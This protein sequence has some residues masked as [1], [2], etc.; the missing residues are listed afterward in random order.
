MPK[1]G[2]FGADFHLGAMQYGDER[3]EADYRR[4]M[5]AFFDAG[6]ANPNVAFLQL[7][8]DTSDNPNE[9]K[10]V[11]QFVR[12]QIK[13]AAQSGKIVYGITGNHDIG[14]PSLAAALDVDGFVDAEKAFL[15]ALARGEAFRPYGE[16]G[17]AV[18]ALHYTTPKKLWE[19]LQDIRNREKPENM[20]TELWLHQ[21]IA[22]GAQTGF[23][24]F[25][26][27]DFVN[28]GW[29]TVI[30]GDI[31]NGGIYPVPARDT[32]GVLVYPGSPEMTDINEY[33]H[34]TRGFVLHSPTDAETTPNIDTFAKIPYANR[35]YRTFRFGT[36]RSPEHLQLILD[37]VQSVTQEREQPIVRIVTTDLSW[38]QSPELLPVVL[39]LMV[40]QPKREPTQMVPTGPALASVEG[41]LFGGNAARY[42][43]VFT[44][45]PLL[46]KLTRVLEASDA[47]DNVKALGAVILSNPGN[48]EKWSA[49]ATDIV[50]EKAAAA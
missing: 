10:N 28:Q 19:K 18:A 49:A 27:V 6:I 48:P 2:L 1:A 16:D 7:G 9:K 12:A 14:E 15:A 40:E 3:R 39:K 29:G 33:E 23:A 34:T 46:A 37:W 11:I 45:E 35:P 47:P 50:P 26:A 41:E 30:S 25:D 4:A 32:N 44:N 43:S 8:G 24:D 38:R 17:P 5:I 31:H 22:P 42:G 21:A 20:S 13:R 36:D